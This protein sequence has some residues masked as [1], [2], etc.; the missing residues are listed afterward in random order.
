M[1]H[2]ISWRKPHPYIQGSDWCHLDGAGFDDKVQGAFTF[3]NKCLDSVK[4]DTFF[5][6]W[7][8]LPWTLVHCLLKQL[9]LSR[10]TSP[11]ICFSQLSIFACNSQRSFKDESIWILFICSVFLLLI[12]SS[13][14]LST[15]AVLFLEE[16]LSDD[17]VCLK[18]I[19]GSVLLWS[20]CL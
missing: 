7:N 17:T 13:R 1:P 19:Y 4:G 6:P 2:L 8:W 10:V 18:S 11:S 14:I 12:S 3:F 9:S 16:S 20:L 15:K 5:F